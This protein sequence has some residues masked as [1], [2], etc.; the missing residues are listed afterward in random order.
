VNNLRSVLLHLFRSVFNVPAG[1]TVA[2]RKSHEFDV[3]ALVDAE[4]PF[5]PVERAKALPTS[6]RVIAM[7]NDDPNFGFFAHKVLLKF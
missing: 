3:G 1:A 6:T 4:S 2:R 7:T 5:L